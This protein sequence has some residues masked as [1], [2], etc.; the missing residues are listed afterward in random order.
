M[1]AVS[2]IVLIEKNYL[3]RAGIEALVLELPGLLIKQVF[4][5]S[6][7]N[8]FDR[9]LQN[10]PDYLIVDPDSILEDFIPLISKFQD[11]KVT[12][13]GLIIKNCPENICSRFNYQLPAEG[14]KHQLLEKLMQITGSSKSAKRE[15]Q[16]PLS[17]REIDVLR[18][19]VKGLTNQEVA[20]KLFLSVHTVMT[21]RKNITRKLGI[22]T[23]SGLMVYAIMNNFLDINEVN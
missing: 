15:K 16:G 17:N 12:L 5:G 3:L 6:E 13:I 7:K 20:D 21:H 23:V 11:E 9:V 14:N 22:K 18:E 8:L 4:D 10:K 2:N 1:S 19:V